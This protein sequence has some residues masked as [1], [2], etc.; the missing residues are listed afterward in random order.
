[1]PT[2]DDGPHLSYAIQWFA[3]AAAIAAFGV[4][5][6]RRGGRASPRPRAAP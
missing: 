1:M 2:L 3:I 4:I 5:V 6:M